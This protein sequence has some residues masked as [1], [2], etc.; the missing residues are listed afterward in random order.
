MQRISNADQ[1]QLIDPFYFLGPRRRRLL[2]AGWPALF[3]KYLYEELPVDAIKSRFHATQGRPTKE[4]HTVLG[5]LV[6][7]QMFDLTDREAVHELAFNI[8]WHYALNLYDEEDDS[9]YV[10]ERTLREYRS[11]VTELGVDEILFQFLTDK[12]LNV[13]KVQTSHQRLDSTHI[14]S[15]MRRLSRLGIFVKTIQKFLRAMKRDHPILLKRHVAEEL[16]GRHLDPK[17]GCF[18]QVK[19]SEARKTL[20]EVAADLLVLVE[21]FRDHATIRVMVEYGLLERVLEDHCE[22]ENEG[23]KVIVKEP[24]AI[25]S[26]SLQNP[27]DPD[28]TYDGHKGQGYQVQLMET[29]QEA[30]GDEREATQ[31]NLITHVNVQPAHESDG[32][33]T[34]VA[35]EETQERGCAPEELVADAAYGSD[36]NV[37]KL[38]EEGVDLTAPALG[39]PGK[40]EGFTLQDFLFVEESD[41]VIACPVGEGPDEIERG[42]NGTVRLY[43]DE[44][45][46]ERCPYEDFCCVG[47]GG[48]NPVLECTAKQRRLAKRRAVEK[49]VEFREKYRWRAGIEATNAQLKRGFHMN[50]LRVR[51]LANVRYAVMLKVLAWNIKQ[52]VRAG[53][54][55]VWAVWGMGNHRLA[56]LIRTRHRIFNTA[57]AP[58]PLPL[59]IR[60]LSTIPPL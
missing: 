1:P 41:E 56:L 12:L 3:R 19:P 58:A 46:C 51:G 26:T 7:Q 13:F 28:A 57:G 45:C 2:E 27:S 9:K 16:V 8:Q 37:Q 53:K 22:V 38:S 14:G 36:A 10:C 6:L 60:L 59:P 42:S 43:F 31:P 4:L 48:E 50:R 15:D 44:E 21:T 39:K 29:Y 49:S 25:P 30:E 55:L 18:S 34:L 33:A 24:K 32:P 52:A 35:L 47:H 40:S 17:E 54:A 23:E 20:Q 5:S 11:L